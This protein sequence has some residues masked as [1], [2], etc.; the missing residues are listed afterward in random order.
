LAFC[1][2]SGLPRGLKNLMGVKWTAIVDQPL[3][4]RQGLAGSKL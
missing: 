2:R 3:S 4:Q 1:F